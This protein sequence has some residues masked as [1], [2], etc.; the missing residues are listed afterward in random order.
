MESNYPSNV[1][2]FWIDESKCT[3]EEFFELI[4]KAFYDN[5]SKRQKVFKVVTLDSYPERI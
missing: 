1:I 2:F 5:A 3:F 4:D